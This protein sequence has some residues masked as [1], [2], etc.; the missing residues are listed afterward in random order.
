MV[1]GSDH[2]GRPRE[3]AGRSRPGG[4][5][6]NSGPTLALGSRLEEL[7]CSAIR[8]APAGTRSP[9]RHSQQPRAAHAFHLFSGRAGCHLPS[10]QGWPL[11]RLTQPGRVWD[12]PT[13]RAT[14]NGFAR[15][16]LRVPPCRLPPVQIRRQARASP[17]FS[18]PAPEGTGVGGGAKSCQPVKIRAR[19]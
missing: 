16:S 3:A 2:S 8:L 7:R 13:E 19:V 15:P 1:P 17:W 12:P 14:G 9:A 5:Q 18:S 4:K 6:P 10:R 11:R